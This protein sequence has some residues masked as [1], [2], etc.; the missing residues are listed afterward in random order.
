MLTGY[1][2]DPV[3]VTDAYKLVQTNRG[4]LLVITVLFP[5]HFLLWR[6]CMLSIFWHFVSFWILIVI[7]F[8]III[9]IASYGIAVTVAC[10]SRFE[11]DL[12]VLYF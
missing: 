12:C 10:I 7:F 2:H 11:L 5:T 6:V 3:L 8:F 9:F 4:Q 1:A